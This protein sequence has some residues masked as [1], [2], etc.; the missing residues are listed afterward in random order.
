MKLSVDRILTTHVGS[1]IR[2]PELVTLLK[3]KEAGTPI[4]DSAIVECQRAAV[5]AVVRTQV[6]MGLD[7]VNDGEFG[8]TISWSRYVLERMSGFVQ[9]PGNDSMPKGVAG[10]DRRDFADFYR[11]YDASQG[12]TRMSPWRVT[13]PIS[14]T[15]QAAIQRDIAELKRALAGLNVTEAFMTAVAPASVV[16]DRD[17]QFYRSDEDYLFAVADALREEYRAIVD[18]G[19]VLQVDD[20]YLAHY[21]DMLVPPG[22]LADYRRWAE[23]RVEVL[24]R[25]LHG[26]PEE[27]TRY[28]VCWGSWNGPHMSDVPLKDIVDIILRVR[29]G[30]YLLEMA[31]PRHEHEWR[32]WE[33]VKLPAGRALIPGVISHATNIVEHPELICDRLVRLAT[34][35]GRESVIA[36]TDCGFAQGPFVQRVH[37]SIM[38]AKLQML[39]EGA[40]LASQ[41]LW[42][43]AERAA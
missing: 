7:V 32:V 8:K 12:L 29:V 20:A 3:A 41:K 38:W 36:G 42:V 1:L 5:A 2:P 16:P 17:D 24:N 28:H 15:G 27:R 10:K 11:Q 25:A 34:L 4:E 18:A 6:T 13:G 14:Y 26:I 30:G 35:L 33:S 9:Q 31:N 23:L 43:G 21:Y 37:P 40:R 19:F 39:V 22:T